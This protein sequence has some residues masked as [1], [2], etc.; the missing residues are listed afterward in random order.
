M[1]VKSL[2]HV[3]VG[4]SRNTHDTAVFN[5]EIREQGINVMQ[6]YILSQN[7]SQILTGQENNTGEIPVAF[8]TQYSHKLLFLFLVFAFEQS[9]DIYRSVL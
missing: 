9:A 1:I 6:Y 8:R 7:I 4:I 2:V 3:N 5:E